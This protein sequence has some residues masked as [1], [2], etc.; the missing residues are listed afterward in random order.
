MI[1][2]GPDD[3][4]GG[5]GFRSFKTAAPIPYPCRWHRDLLI[6][7]TL[8][9]SIEALERHTCGPDE[10]FSVV[11][12]VASTRRLVT[13]LRKHPGASSDALPPDRTW[14]LRSV[15]LAEPRCSTA[16]M[17]WATRR[18]KVSLGDRL[19]ILQMLEDCPAGS[20]LAAAGKCVRSDVG[21]PA[22]AILALVCAGQ[23][24][25]DIRNTL[26]P[27][28]WIRRRGQGVGER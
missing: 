14:I 3:A 13:A 25:I 15:V 26:S 7:M 16:R 6:Q 1:L 11:A 12:I 20:T 17:V 18:T 4:G 22:D 10:N 9:P 21:D 24:D 28:T 8:D 19:R 5:R 27:Q 23:V 2:D